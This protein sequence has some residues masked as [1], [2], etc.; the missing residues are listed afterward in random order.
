[1]VILLNA[2]LGGATSPP[3]STP[4]R[5]WGW[6][7]Q[8]WLLLDSSGPPIRNLA[9]V[10]YDTRRQL[11]VMHGG[12]YGLGRTYAETWEWSGAW[13]QVAATGPGAR[14]HTQLAFDADRGRAVLFGGSG[15]NPNNLFADTWEYDG[16]AWS[17]AATEGPPARVHH[18]MHY[19]AGTRRV[20]LAGGTSPATGTLGDVWTWDGSRWS[21]AGSIDAPR[22][23]AR[24]TFHRGLDAL[25]LAG[26]LPSAGFSLVAGRNGMWRSVAGGIT[27]SARYLTDLAYDERRNVVVLFGGDSPS[28][29]LADTWELDGTTWRQI[30]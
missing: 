23:H 25:L 7:G 29:L 8:E 28:G 9:G 27:P 24:M 18:A 21:A 5:V 13:R 17:R 10:A 26:G 15:D 30:R 14:D 19:D 22:S 6:N 4:T 11:V 16:T 12:G 1:M 2:G 20:T 3:S